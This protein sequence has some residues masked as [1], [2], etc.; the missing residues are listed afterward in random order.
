MAR[1]E[2]PRSRAALSRLLLSLITTRGVPFAQIAYPILGVHV[3][4]S[5]VRS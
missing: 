3:S 2:D 5:R 1:A 4:Q